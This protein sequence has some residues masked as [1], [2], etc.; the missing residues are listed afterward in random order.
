MRSSWLCTHKCKSRLEVKAKVL[1]TV[2]LKS[3]PAGSD[4]S[5]SSLI[6]C[7]LSASTC[8]RMAWY[9]LSFSSSCSISLESNELGAAH[10]NESI[11]RMKANRNDSSKRVRSQ[12]VLS[13]LPAGLKLHPAQLH[14]HGALCIVGLARDAGAE[15][16]YS[17]GGHGVVVSRDGGRP[18]WVGGASL[19]LAV[20]VSVLLLGRVALGGQAEVR[21]Q[22]CTRTQG[23][24]LMIYF[25]D[26][27][28]CGGN[29]KGHVLYVCVISIE[30][31]R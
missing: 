21:P 24:A 31:E 15:R 18:A 2:R 8:C 12:R 1:Q 3:T 19:R 6:S 22:L 23:A 5:L 9:S 14:A 16:A 4:R 7:S 11:K 25:G 30:S 27:V 10:V 13:W 28:S 26:Y 17:G 29:W 20:V